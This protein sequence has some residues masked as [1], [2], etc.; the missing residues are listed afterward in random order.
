MW[1]LLLIPMVWHMGFQSGVE[2][3]RAS[4]KN[5]CAV[6]WVKSGALKSEGAIRITGNPKDR[7]RSSAWAPIEGIGPINTNSQLTF[8]AK[9]NNKPMRVRIIFHPQ[10]G[11]SDYYHLWKTV[12]LTTKWQKITIPLNGARPIWSS[13]YPYVLTPGEKPDL[14][15]FFENL[16][17]GHFDVTIDEI[18]LEKGG[19]Q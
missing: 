11:S 10:N 3:F 4:T 13:N 1:L 2:G 15:L 18:S 5:P 6:S 12:N 14:F 8:W 16:Q 17:P 9:G 19:S 7:G